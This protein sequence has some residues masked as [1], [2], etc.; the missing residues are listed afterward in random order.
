MLHTPSAFPEVGSW[1]LY[2]RLGLT[3]AARIAGLEGEG[4]ERLATISL[5]DVPN[6]SSGRLTVPLAEILDATPLTADEVEQKAA[7]ETYLGGLAAPER[8]SKAPLYDALCRRE[9]H[10]TKLVELLGG[11]ERRKLATAA[12]REAKRF[13]EAA[14]AAGAMRRAA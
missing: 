14:I 2:Q 11:L 3:H 7:L 4:E 6:A 1:A 12:T 5:A 10:A 8:S 13:F 9:A